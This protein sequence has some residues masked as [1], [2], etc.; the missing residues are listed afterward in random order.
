MYM[1]MPTTFLADGLCFD[2]CCSKTTAPANRFVSAS[3][4]RLISR[5]STS[6]DLTANPIR[7]SLYLYVE[8]Q[9]T[10]HPSCTI[11]S[12]T[13]GSHS[14]CGHQRQ[15]ARVHREGVHCRDCREHSTSHRHPHCVCHGQR[16]G[17]TP[18][19]HHTLIHGQ[20]QQWEIQ[21]QLRDR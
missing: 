15:P 7:F 11:H 20:G 17:W 4:L 9:E 5:N 19:L 18:L 2:Q 12:P 21:D 14:S 8:Y 10:P 1:Y 16:Q 6:R 3:R 13:T